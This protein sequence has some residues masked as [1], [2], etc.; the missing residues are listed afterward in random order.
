MNAKKCSAQ[1]TGSVKP[2]DIRNECRHLDLD[3]IVIDYLLLLGSDVK[4]GNRASEVGAISKA[5]K[6]LAMELRVHIILLSQ[7]NRISEAKETKEPAMAEIRESG[8]VE[9]DASTIILLWN[10]DQENRNKKGVKIEKNR[11]GELGKI[12][13]EFDGAIMQFIE[14]DGTI[15]PR[16]NGFTRVKKTP[17][18]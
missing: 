10:T 14:L 7:L 16:G 17:F 9:Q 3:Y 6:A 11:Q 15:E 4:Y 1:M 13:F 18:D 12:P 5:I 8:D 2:S